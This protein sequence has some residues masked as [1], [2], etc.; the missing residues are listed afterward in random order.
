MAKIIDPDDISPGVEVLLTPSAKTIKLNISGNL[1]TDGLNMNTLYSW[2][3]EQWKTDTE[4]IKYPFPLVAITVEQFELV[5]GWTFAD[6]SS[7]NLIR[8][9]GWT[10]KDTASVTQEIFMNLTTLGAFD[11]SGAD[12][13]YYL[14]SQS[15]VPTSV[16]LTGPV[17]QAI[18]IFGDA[19]HGNFDYTTFFKVYLREEEKTYGFYDLI[20][21]QNL[22]VLENKKY[23]LPLSNGLDLKTTAADSIIDSGSTGVPTTSP[24]DLMSLTY[25]SGSGFTTMAA[26]AYSV[27]DVVQD[28]TGRWFVC[29]VAGTATGTDVSTGSGTCTF[30]S[31]TGEREI[32]AAWYAYNIIT[33]GANSTAEEIYT[34]L[35]FQLRQSLD[36]DAGAGVVRG[37]TAT[38]LAAFVGDTLITNDGV[39]IDNFQAVDTN[40]LTFTDVLGVARTFPYVAAGTLFFNDNLQTDTASIY[41][42]FFTNDNAGDNAG[43]DYGTSGAIT[44]N[45]NSGTPIAGDVATSASRT[46]DFDYDFNVQRGAAS[47]GSDAPYTAVAIGLVGAQFVVTTGTIVRSTTNTINFVAA[48]ER[49]YSNPV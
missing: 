42:V 35:Q 32:G 25:L 11:D 24:Y 40:R 27:D 34:Y 8:D 12:Q 46:F 48:L 30:I 23:A 26:Q 41:R 5:S 7:E 10:L 2:T 39:Y 16:V 18:K 29:T 33:D 21:E 36:I 47:S 49:N 4:L 19:T 6:T 20:L 31:Y 15:G 22:T 9:G 37:D 14:Q 13:A 45:D 38:E 17:N 44:I 3:K 28:S 43:N 1:S